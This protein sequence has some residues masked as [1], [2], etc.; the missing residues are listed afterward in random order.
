MAMREMILASEG[1]MGDQGHVRRLGAR[2]R[3]Q[4]LV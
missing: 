3:H 1:S 2:R 4:L